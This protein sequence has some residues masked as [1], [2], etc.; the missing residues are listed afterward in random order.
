MVV[1]GTGNSGFDVAA[2]AYH[3]GASVTMVQRSKTYVISLE[4]AYKFITARYNEKSVLF[5]FPSTLIIVSK[6][7]IRVYNAEDSD[8]LDASTP[9]HL[10]KSIGSEIAGLFAKADATTLDGVRCVGFQLYDEPFPSSIV[11]GIQRGRVRD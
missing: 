1:I 10:S 11:L 5:P 4:L 9:T 2:E 3:T 8:L 7:T 6:L